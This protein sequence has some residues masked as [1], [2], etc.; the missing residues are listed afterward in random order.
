MNLKTIL[1]AT[2]IFLTTVS[3]SFADKPKPVRYFNR[4]R[5]TYGEPVYRRTVIVRHPV[6]RYAPCRRCRYIVR[7][8]C[9]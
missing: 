2:I 6:Y 1:L 3:I 9:R 5:I 7:H 4:P 8:P